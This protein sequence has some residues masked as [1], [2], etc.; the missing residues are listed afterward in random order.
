MSSFSLTCHHDLHG[1][2]PARRHPT[3]CYSRVL[4]SK[5][6]SFLCP[7]E[8]TYSDSILHQCFLTFDW[9][10]ASASYLSSSKS[11]R[12]CSDRHQTC[13]GSL[14]QTSSMAS[15]HPSYS[16]HPVS[17]ATAQCLSSY[18]HVRASSH[19]CYYYVSVAHASCRVCS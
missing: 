13:L 14:Y 10:L 1:W 6:Y 12:Y 18:G 4:G 11:I 7:S 5:F 3:C 15:P 17:S 2:H 16:A 9:R 8:V 19:P